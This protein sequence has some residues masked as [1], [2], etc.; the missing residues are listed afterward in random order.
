MGARQ[1]ATSTSPLMVTQMIHGCWGAVC[2][3]YASS[4]ARRS[5]ITV[6]VQRKHIWAGTRG[7]GGGGRVSRDEAFFL[8]PGRKQ[9]GLVFFFFWHAQRRNP[10]PRRQ[11][12]FPALA[13]IPGWPAESCV[14]VFE[15]VL[16]AKKVDKRQGVLSQQSLSQCPFLV[17]CLYF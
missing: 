14:R 2:I 9:K 13:Q 4:S 5:L 16:I 15:G 1:G 12:H 7:R 6:Y 11:L 8:A 3:H 17:V 10:A